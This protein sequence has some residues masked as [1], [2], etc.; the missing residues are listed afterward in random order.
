MRRRWDGSGEEG[1]DFK[2]EADFEGHY[3]PT[4]CSSQSLVFG[5][6]IFGLLAQGRQATTIAKARRAR[7]GVMLS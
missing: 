7:S 4:V 5:S 2:A 3:H 1:K 6:R